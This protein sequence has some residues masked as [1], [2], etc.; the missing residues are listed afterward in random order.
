MVVGKFK[1][2]SPGLTNSSQKLD[3]LERKVGLFAL[4]KIQ[5]MV[6]LGPW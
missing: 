3:S 6:A 5:G 4:S 2:F 1:M